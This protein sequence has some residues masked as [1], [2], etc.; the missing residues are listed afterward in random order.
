MVPFHLD[1]EYPNRIVLLGSKLRAEIQAELEQF[2]LEY[3][4]VFAWSYEDMPGIDQAVMYHR[5]HVNPK[6]KLVIFQP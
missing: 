1:P 5:L 4:D 6:H 3:R 2:L